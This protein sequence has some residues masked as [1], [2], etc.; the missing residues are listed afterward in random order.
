MRKN[1]ISIFL[2]L[3]INNIIVLNHVA[4]FQ[5]SH[6]FISSIHIKNEIITSVSYTSD[7]R[8]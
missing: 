5:P 8:H 6:R 4:Y 3:I 7:F 1:N 2:Y